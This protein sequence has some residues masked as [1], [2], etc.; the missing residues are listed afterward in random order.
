ML[1]ESVHSNVIKEKKGG[2]IFPSGLKVEFF[3]SFFLCAIRI[4]GFGQGEGRLGLASGAF[5]ALF[6][7]L[8]EDFEKEASCG[9]SFTKSL[10]S[11]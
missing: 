3:K 1:H 7:Q 8:A 5:L 4:C 6:I 10:S 9:L 2:R 11:A